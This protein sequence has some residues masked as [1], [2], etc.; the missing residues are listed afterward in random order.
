MNDKKNDK[1][2]EMP[3]RG[4]PRKKDNNV[5]QVFK[6]D[7]LHKNMYSSSMGYLSREN[8]QE[9]MNIGSMCPYNIGEE[10][11]LLE[12]FTKIGDV[13]NNS[14]MKDKEEVSQVSPKEVQNGKTNYI[15]NSSPSI[16]NS[17]SPDVISSNNSK[18]FESINNNNL[19]GLRMSESNYNMSPHQANSIMT[20]KMNNNMSPRQDNIS[21]SY[22]QHYSPNQFIQQQ[23]IPQQG[24]PKQPYIPPHYEEKHKQHF[25]QNF[26]SKQDPSD[27]VDRR[28]SIYYDGN[29]GTVFSPYYTNSRPNI[30]SANYYKPPQNPNFF[31]QSPNYFR[32]SINQADLIENSWTYKKKRKNNPIMWNYVKNSGDGFQPL[33]HPSKYSSLDY[34][35][36]NDIF[37]RKHNLERDCNNTILPLF[38]NSNKELN[39]E[40]SQVINNFKGKVSELDFTNVTVHQ[41]KLLMREF[42]LNHT[43]KKNELIDRAKSTLKKIDVSVTNAK[44]RATEEAKEENK[45]EDD[46][47]NVF[48]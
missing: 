44:K 26:F 31:R 23:Y 28:S 32:P 1:P 14:N 36:G 2:V 7:Y 17:R 13:F 46:Y 5:E 42:G 9:E 15:Y 27:Q 37:S 20:Q 33:I 48:F 10:S 24:Y 19:N 30:N 43:G 6:N 12:Q 41:L 47:E 45:E 16:M 40:Y 11:S 21:T 34:I 8:S 22:Q 18:R 39:E 38:L 4:R 35:Q 25:Q 3:A 29:K